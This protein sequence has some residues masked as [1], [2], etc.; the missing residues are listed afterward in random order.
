MASV[1]LDHDDLVI[2]NDAGAVRN[3]RNMRCLTDYNS[4]IAF[5]RKSSR[6]TPTCWWWWMRRRRPGRGM[7]PAEPP[8]VEGMI[9]QYC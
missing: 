2:H 4:D 9:R 6:M 8:L 7:R 5:Y 3:E 1:A